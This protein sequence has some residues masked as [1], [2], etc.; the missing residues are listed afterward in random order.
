[1]PEK[2]IVDLFG[3]FGLFLKHNMTIFSVFDKIWPK[4]C[5]GHVT[6]KYFDHLSQKDEKVW[7]FHNPPVNAHC[8]LIGP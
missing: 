5:Q 8:A 4:S 6:N 1:M 2:P 3:L 7:I